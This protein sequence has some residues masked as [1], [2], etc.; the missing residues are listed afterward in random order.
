MTSAV[1][2]PRDA[3]LALAGLLLLMAWKLPPW[4]VVVVLASAGAVFGA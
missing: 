1:H 4:A 2:T 3:L